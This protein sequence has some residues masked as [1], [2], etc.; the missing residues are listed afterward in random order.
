MS[1]PVAGQIFITVD[2]ALSVVMAYFAYKTFALP[3]FQ[4]FAEAFE[5]FADANDKATDYWGK[6]FKE[7]GL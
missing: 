5:K 2:L 4:E 1:S 3:F 7:L 6:F